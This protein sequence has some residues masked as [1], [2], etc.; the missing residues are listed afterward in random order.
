[1]ELVPLVA[2]IQMNGVVV[3]ACAWV[4]ATKKQKRALEVVVFLPDPSQNFV[5][6]PII[7]QV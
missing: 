4:K 3:F 1:M 5:V 2:E 6:V 7:I